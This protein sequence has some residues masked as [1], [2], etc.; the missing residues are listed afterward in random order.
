MQSAGKRND[1]INP[2]GCLFKLGPPL[3]T[4]HKFSQDLL[5]CLSALHA[6]K[7]NQTAEMTLAQQQLLIILGHS[8]VWRGQIYRMCRM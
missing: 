1:S 8:D 6:D 2:V 3:V 5:F 4:V 7:S